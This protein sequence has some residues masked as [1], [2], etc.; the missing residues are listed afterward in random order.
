MAENP[1]VPVLLGTDVPELFQLLGRPPEV[2]QP[3]EVLLVLTRQRARQQ[4]EEEILR[5]EKE[6]ASGAQTRSVGESN[7]GS[8]MVGPEESNGETPAVPKTLKSILD[9]S[10]V[11]LHQLQEQDST[12]ADIRHMVADADRKGEEG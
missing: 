2:T 8:H 5:K 4:L 6:R 1:T 12:L 11:E 10:A 7:E 3:Q 9:I